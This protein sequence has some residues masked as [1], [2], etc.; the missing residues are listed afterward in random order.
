MSLRQATIT[1]IKW[2]SFSTGA[3]LVIQIVQLVVLGRLLKPE[4][5]GLMTM[6]LV[7]VG[8]AQAYAD[9]GVSAAIVQRQDVTRDQ[10]STLYWLNIAVGVA[11][12]G[13]VCAASPL[14]SWFFNEPLLTRLLPVAASAFVLTSTGQQ[15]RWLLEKDLHFD[16]LARQ[17]VL[18]SSLGA[19]ATIA[20]ALYGLGVWSLAIGPLVT[21]FLK[22]AL[23]VG[24]GWPR[25]A[26]AFHFRGADLR[27]FAAFGLYQMG[28]RTMN[29]VQSRIDQIAI[30]RLLGAQEL[31]YYNFA[32]SLVTHPSS[33]LNPVVTRVAFPVFARMQADT[34]GLRRNYVKMLN[35]LTTLNAPILAGAAAVAPLL[36]PLVFGAKWAPAVPL[37]QIL[38]LYALVR[39]IGNPIGALL[40][41]KGRA[42]LSFRWLTCVF[43]IT[44]PVVITG[45]RLS[46]AIGIGIALNLLFV[47][48]SFAG[49]RFL[50]VPLIGPCARPY[51]AAIL[52]PCALAAAMA[53]VVAGLSRVLPG[54]WL[55]LS[56]EIAIG[57][58]VYGALV[59]LAEP[60]LLGEL[61]TLIRPGGAATASEAGTGSGR[62]PSSS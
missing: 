5:F 58:V 37:V 38:A 21:A 52:K 12:F 3:T 27:G 24:K 29:Y 43:L 61:S 42:D 41:S 23:L 39:S 22:A 26:P 40:L 54:S 19:V 60:E 47:A 20:M 57:V 1:G 31:G 49:Y 11:L 7:V 2:T 6:A 18:A 32:L 46:G 33:L 9:M 55:G 35:V 51:A 62:G 50:V 44:V 53:A 15:F 13:L 28:E 8:F 25:W 14:V 16:V 59:R 30:G 34:E 45:G 4:D 36:I 56:L 48:Y 17:E 10:L